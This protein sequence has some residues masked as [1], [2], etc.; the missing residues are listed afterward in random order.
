MWHQRYSRQADLD[1]TSRTACKPH[2]SSWPIC[3]YETKPLALRYCQHL[4]SRTCLNA[5]KRRSILYRKSFAHCLAMM[6]TSLCFSVSAYRRFSTATWP[7]RAAFAQ[8]T[9]AA[10]VLIFCMRTAEAAVTIP[11]LPKLSN[12][13]LLLQPGL[14]LRHATHRS[15]TLSKSRKQM[16]CWLNKYCA[17]CI[18]CRP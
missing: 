18:K 3:P 6:D 14:A 17:S 5:I 1:P 13:L 7:R 15:A 4:R 11:T 10:Q 9:T 12:I 2:C 16:P 8:T